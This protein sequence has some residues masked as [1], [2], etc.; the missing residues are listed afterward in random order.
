MQLIRNTIVNFHDDNASQ[1]L[2]IWSQHKF[3]N[4]E[5]CAYSSIEPKKGMWEREWMK[6][7][8]VEGRKLFVPHHSSIICWSISL[9]WIECW[10]F[11][12]YWFFR[13]VNWCDNNHIFTAIIINSSQTKPNFSLSLS[14]T[15]TRIV[16]SFEIRFYS[17]S[18]M[19]KSK[20]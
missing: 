13:W 18:A 14:L 5:K 9:L 20:I 7:R 3:K 15:P 4:C 17:N 12:F 1:W 11:S 8:E 19:N 6:E 10:Y 16:D 2:V